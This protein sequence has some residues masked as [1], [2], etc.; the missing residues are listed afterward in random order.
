MRQQRSRDR[1]MWVVVVPTRLASRGLIRIGR[2]GSRTAPT[3]VVVVGDE[4]QDATSTLRAIA[5]C[6]DSRGTNEASDTAVAFANRPLC[7][8]G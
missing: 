6:G 1:P 3:C 7:L 2:G 5:L 8:S 4:D